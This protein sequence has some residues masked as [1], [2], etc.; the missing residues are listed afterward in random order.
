MGMSDQP[1]E[2]RFRP[3][4]H[5]RFASEYL[6]EIRELARISKRSSFPGILQRLA[7]YPAFLATQASSPDPTGR[8]VRASGGSGMMDLYASKN[9]LIRDA[10]ATAHLTA[11]CHLLHSSTLMLEQLRA[12]QLLPLAQQFLDSCKDQSEDYRNKMIGKLH[13]MDA[14]RTIQLVRA[15]GLISRP[16]SEIYQLGIGAAEGTRDILSVHLAPSIKAIDCGGAVGYHL[17]AEKQ[18]AAETIIVDLDPGYREHYENLNKDAT[19][20]VRAYN[21]KT[22]DALTLIPGDTQRG[23]NLITGLRIDHRM[24]PDAA[25][26]FKRLV[27][28]LDE[29]ADFLLTIGAGDTVQDFEGRIEKFRELFSGLE[30]AGLRPLLFKLHGPGSPAKQRYSLK[31]GNLRASSY[32]I[33]YCRMNRVKLAAAFT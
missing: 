32:Q 25:E 5:E 18:L 10:L 20:N 33:L 17:L 8:V 7:D 30:G 23:C 6:I 9:D 1:S 22:E 13:A 31:V 11:C 3:D 16:T 26:F 24:L 2:L 19:M 12:A 14:I 21:M 29:E 15:L 27:A 28:C 4:T